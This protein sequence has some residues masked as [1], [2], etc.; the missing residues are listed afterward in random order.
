MFW[1]FTS[2]NFFLYYKNEIRK[3]NSVNVQAG[4]ILM[5]QSG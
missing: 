4:K 1:N 2:A 5:Q 3:F